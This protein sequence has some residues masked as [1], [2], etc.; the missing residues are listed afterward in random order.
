VSKVFDLHDAADALKAVEK[1][2]VFKALLKPWRHS[3]H[4]I[5][6]SYTLKP[7]VPGILVNLLMST[8]TLVYF[9]L[10]YKIFGCSWL[11]PLYLLYVYVCAH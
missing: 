5:P 3:E 6:K 8:Y 1:L 9:V 10:Y 2:E 4:T 11:P 7:H